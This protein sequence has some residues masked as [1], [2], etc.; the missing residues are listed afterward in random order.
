MAEQVQHGNSTRARPLNLAVPPQ[1][2]FC[3][4]VLNGA[5]VYWE[6]KEMVSHW[7]TF[8]EIEPTNIILYLLCPTL[9]RRGIKR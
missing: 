7:L 3:D 1:F 9:N 6:K 5:V 4:E 8:Y 2:F